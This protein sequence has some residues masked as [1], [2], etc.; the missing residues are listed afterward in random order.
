MKG[1]VSLGEVGLGVDVDCGCGLYFFWQPTEAYRGVQGRRREGWWM[2]LGNG[3]VRVDSDPK[4]RPQRSEFFPFLFWPSRQN[5]PD[6]PE[7]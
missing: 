1:R 7:L 6:G 5:G 4:E 2:E 3:I